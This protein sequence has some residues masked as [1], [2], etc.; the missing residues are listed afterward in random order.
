MLLLYFKAISLVSKLWVSQT[1]SYS[2]KFQDYCLK[3]S[4]NLS[5]IKIDLTTMSQCMSNIE[6]LGE[7][8]PSKNILSVGAE[9][10]KEC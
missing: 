3:K 8:V 9:T 10:E 5:T 1:Q 4:R 7:I 2:F 6:K